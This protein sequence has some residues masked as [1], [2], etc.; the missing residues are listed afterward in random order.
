M[1]HDGLYVEAAASPDLILLNAPRRLDCA[2]HSRGSTTLLLLGVEQ[3]SEL[4][5]S[6]DEAE[7]PVALPL[8]VMNAVGLQFVFNHL[9]ND[10]LNRPI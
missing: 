5:D 6:L 9:F 7:G 10:R 3:G 8:H 4:F 1:H 2:N